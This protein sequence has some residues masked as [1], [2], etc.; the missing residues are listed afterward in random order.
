MKLE[1]TSIMVTAKNVDEVNKK[2]EDIGYGPSNFSVPI[3]VGNGK[4]TTHYGC[5]WNISADQLSKLDG[6]MSK[7]KDK[8]VAVKQKEDKVAGKTFDSMLATAGA[9]KKPQDDTKP[10]DGKP[11]D[12]KP[13]DIIK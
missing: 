3:I 1:Q 13:K 8:E 5:S 2:L 11:V 10:T 4:D 12:D 9:K 7:L 6:I